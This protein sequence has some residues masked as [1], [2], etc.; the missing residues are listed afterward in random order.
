MPSPLTAA[1]LRTLRQ[2]WLL[3]YI[4]DH[5]E[6]ASTAK[7]SESAA[8]GGTSLVLSGLGAGTIPAGTR[9][10][11]RAAGRADTYTVAA[12]A[13]IT[14][15]AATVTVSPP[16]RQ[17]VPDDSPVERVPEYG[18]VYNAKTNSLFWTDAQLQEFAV[19][20]WRE[21][22]ERIAQDPGEASL[23]RAVRLVANRHRLQSGLFLEFQAR[24][25]QEPTVLLAERTRIQDLIKDDETQL[26]PAG[27]GGFTRPMWK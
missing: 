10:T 23:L 27:R 12:A 4:E 3:D 1:A 25:L 21:Y 6:I 22:G 8:A 26:R 9:L 19:Q 18:D 13:T 7:V 16:L 15:G 24:H 11:V 17:A 2:T 14:A 20:A 5:L